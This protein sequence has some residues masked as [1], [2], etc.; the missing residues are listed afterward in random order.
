[1]GLNV[2]RMIL[3]AGMGWC[4]FRFFERAI[5][6]TRIDVDL[7]HIHAMFTRIADQLRGGVKAHGLRV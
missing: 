6:I 3:M 5:P 1:M 2:T 7:A 4:A